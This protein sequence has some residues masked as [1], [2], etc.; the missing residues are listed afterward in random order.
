MPYN[1]TL[2]QRVFQSLSARY[3]ITPM[4]MFGGMAFLLNGKM[5]CGIINDALVVRIGPESYGD[6]LQEPYTRPMDF[7]G[8]PMKGMVYVSPAGYTTDRALD[9]WVGRATQYVSSLRDEASNKKRQ[10]RRKD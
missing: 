3:P 6:A 1:E 4:K 2:A 9:L 5:C 8:R 7:T 10:K